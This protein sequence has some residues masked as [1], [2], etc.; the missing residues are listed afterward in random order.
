MGFILNDAGFFEDTFRQM[1]S[2]PEEGFKL[3]LKTMPNR[4]NVNIYRK[5]K[6]PN[7]FLK[8]GNEKLYK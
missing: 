6:V 3:L 5:V 2:H 8:I 4:A 1:D 7:L